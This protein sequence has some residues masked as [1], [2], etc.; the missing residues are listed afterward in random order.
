LWVFKNQDT[1]SSG[2]TKAVFG[3]ILANVLIAVSKFVAAF[4]TGS[5]A[6]VSEGIHSLVDSMNG[7]LLLLGIKRSKK[8]PDESHP[9]GYGLELYFWSFVVAIL[10]FALGGGIALYEGVHHLLHPKPA[11][12]ANP[13]WNFA[14][15]GIAVLVEGSSLIYALKE[16]NLSNKGKG[17]IQS[18]RESK[19]AVTFSVI[20][21]ETAAIIGLLIALLGVTLVLVTGNILFDALA[22][23]TIGLLL[24]GVSAFMAVECKSLIV[25][26]SAQKVD[27]DKIEELLKSKNYIDSYDRPKTLHF[28]P[29]SILVAI[30]VDFTNALTTENIE[31]YTVELENNIRSINPHFDRIYIESKAI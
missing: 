8:D 10:V 13:I 11:T 14:V 18:I 30:D 20:I 2:S 4:F 15:L 5:S 25:G 9:F 29:E 28:G 26:E 1:M 12:D 31:K 23:I 17:F 16:F 27:V 22:S 19:D 21:E 7:L 24:C 3:A 6:M